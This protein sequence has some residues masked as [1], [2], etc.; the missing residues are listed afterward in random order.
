MG[1]LA[2][3]IADLKKLLGK[4]VVEEASYAKHPI[5]QSID[6][7]LTYHDSGDYASR[8]Y[9]NSSLSLFVKNLNEIRSHDKKLLRLFRGALQSCNSDTYFGYRFEVSVASSLIRGQ[10]P[11]VKMERPDFRL[12]D[13]WDGLCIECGSTHLSEPK[14]GIADLKYKVGSVIREKSQHDYCDA[15]SALFIDFTN[16]NYHSTLQEILPG[17]NELKGYVADQLQVSGF[18]SV[19]L[20]TYI[21]NLDTR[22]YQW[23]YTRIDNKLARQLL[24]VFLDTLYPFGYDVTH[25]YGFLSTG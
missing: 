14:L 1:S 11:F 4:Q 22:R 6:R 8:D 21:V 5:R 18:G 17:V 12:L 23:K 20:W 13:Q 19:I 24:V 10:V 16:I 15:G 25:N 7:V 2:E 3:N 9:E